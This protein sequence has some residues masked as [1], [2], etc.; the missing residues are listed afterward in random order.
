MRKE[1]PFGRLGVQQNVKCFC[2]STINIR[3]ARQNCHS[4]YILLPKRF[5][6]IWFRNYPWMTHK[7]FLQVNVGLVSAA[8]SSIWALGFLLGGWQLMPRNLPRGEGNGNPLQDSCLENPVDRGSWWAAVHGVAK[9]QT[10]LSVH[11]QTHTPQNS[12]TRV[13]ARGLYHYYYF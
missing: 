7:N 5:F 2:G 3:R 4:H 12:S 6:C 1:D 10:R 11:T 13:C 8:K 9:S